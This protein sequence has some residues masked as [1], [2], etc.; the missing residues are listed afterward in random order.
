MQDETI[1]SAYSP[2]KPGLPLEVISSEKQEALDHL[3]QFFIKQ[4]AGPATTQR[5][6]LKKKCGL[7]T[8]NMGVEITLGKRQLWVPVGLAPMK[9]EAY[10]AGLDL[11]ILPERETLNGR[12]KDP[13]PQKVV[14]AY[15]YH[16]DFIHVGGIQ[17]RDPHAKTSRSYWLIGSSASGIFGLNLLTP[18]QLDTVIMVEGPHDALA[19]QALALARGEVYPIVAVGGTMS[20]LLAAKRLR[21]LGYKQICIWPDN[22]QKGREAAERANFYDVGIIYPE[23]YQEDEDPC[24]FIK[25]LGD[26]D[27]ILDALK[28][29]QR[30]APKRLPKGY[31]FGS[32]RSIWTQK[33]IKIPQK[34]GGGIKYERGQ[35][36]CLSPTHVAQRYRDETGTLWSELSW[37][38]DELHSLIVPRVSLMDK[39]GLI[40]SASR[41]LLVNSENATRLTAYLTGYEYENRKYLT[42]RAASTRLGWVTPKSFLWGRHCL[43]ER[44]IFLPSGTEDA[45][46]ADAYSAEGDPKI[47]RDLARQVY[48]DHPI[49]RFVMNA[50]AAATLV[51]K[52]TRRTLLIYLFGE[53]GKGKSAAEMM[54]I[55]LFGHPETLSLTF[56]STVVGLERTLGLFAD[57]PLVI[58][59]K[60]AAQHPDVVN[61]LVY[62]LSSGRG[63]ARGA[64]TGGLQKTA[65]WRSL[66][67]ASGEE[68]L[69]SSPWRGIANRALEVHITEVLPEDLARKVH[70][71]CAAHYGHVAEAWFT[72]LLALAAGEL[73]TLHERFVARL[74]K[75]CPGAAESHIDIAALITVA[76][77]LL[78]PIIL[79]G[80]DEAEAERLSLE[81]AQIILG[82]ISNDPQ[83]SLAEKALE[84]ALGWASEKVAEAAARSRDDH[85]V[86]SPVV[87]QSEE[88]G[89]CLL[90]SAFS[91][92]LRKASY[93]PRRVLADWAE[94]GW[95]EI[96]QEGN[97]RRFQKP[98]RRNGI[99]ARYVVFTEEV[100]NREE[101]ED[102]DVDF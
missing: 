58:D 75:A 57:L 16:S 17:W 91:E 5:E 93:T 4:L 32:D 15:L 47:W 48:K 63:K 98:I 80:I 34:D 61:R 28:R 69:S 10:K 95:V 6:W 79:E 92:A 44:V 29:G 11:S 67:I 12:S 53:S 36:V 55:S 30:I 62:I 97:E 3:A 96:S 42:P 52:L 13:W 21:K 8:D 84:F 101:G 87:I 23:D 31:M 2:P 9:A 43:G 100:L 99:L 40:E 60:Q 45:S 49:A 83:E 76:G 72:R 7:S 54:A 38:N 35:L 82:R 24:D 56:F 78:T 66:V 65:H 18:D 68:D 86:E 90:W 74:K 64:K 33:K 25:R 71:V 102:D 46:I 37:T 50:A 73:E 26:L 81:A 88:D 14:M 39:T 89:L 20:Y 41:G 27:K 22:D 94:L 1:H 85:P 19:L 70:Q 77:C 59:E 51:R